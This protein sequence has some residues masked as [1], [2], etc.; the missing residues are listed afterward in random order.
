MSDDKKPRKHA[1]D[2]AEK[3]ASKKRA[4]DE[5]T[6]AT[7]TTTAQELPA[8]ASPT[9]KPRTSASHHASAAAPVTSTAAPTNAA[10]ESPIHLQTTS[11]Y[12][13][14]ASIGQSY[15]L[16]ALCAE[17]LSPL[18][19]T[20]YPPL[21]GVVLS[22]SN[23]RLS[24]APAAGKSAHAPVLARSIDEYAVS[25]AWLTA[26]FVVLR[27][28]P[29]ALLEG[30]VNLQN[31][32]HLGLVCWNLF[33]ASVDRRRLPADWV[34][35]EGGEGEASD[36]QEATDNDETAADGKKSTNAHTPA[37]GQGYYTSASGAPIAG[38]I[39]FRVRDVEMAPR[40]GEDRGFVSIE[41]TLLG[42]EQERAL[43]EQEL[44]RWAQR[45]QGPRR[46]GR[47]RVALRG[48]R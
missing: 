41:G 8:H 6:A 19:L 35:V 15:A 33:S 28:R 42:E 31:E 4:R 47:A 38:K 9:K 11:F 44:A 23:A 24:E 27:P 1:K 29:G 22:Y 20:Y 40:A 37:A 14:L 36:Y 39:S 3:K 21:S 34:W 43:D 45:A 30:I 46:G 17:H 5:D 13:P 25:F 26:D 10:D 2:R 48:G 32:S 12:L 16:E 7:S 18:L